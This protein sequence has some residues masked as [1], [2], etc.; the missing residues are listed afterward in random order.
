MSLERDFSRHA[1]RAGLSSWDRGLLA[2]AV[3]LFVLSG[4]VAG[5]AQSAVVAARTRLE[6]VRRESE[7]ARDRLRALESRSGKEE[8]LASRILLTAEAPP[9]RIVADLAALV[10]ADVRLDSVGLAYGRGVELELQVVARRAQA[11]DLFLRR[12]AESPRISAVSPGTENRDGE[13]RASVRATYTRAGSLR[14]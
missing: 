1:R 5:R 6:A 7:G 4:Y 2:A 11:Y 9:P 3:A 10:P 12:L 14:E 13:V 8:G